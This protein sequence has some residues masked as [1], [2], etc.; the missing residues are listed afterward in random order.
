[1]MHVQWRVKRGPASH[2]GSAVWRKSSPEK[3]I[4]IDLLSELLLRLNWRRVC[5]SRPRTRVPGTNGRP[6][7]WPTSPARAS[8]PKG[9]S[10]FLRRDPGYQTGSRRP[11]VQA[12]VLPNRHGA[13]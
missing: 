7:Y 5:G 2:A 3:L 8:P 6:A 10:R 4:E 1:M 12:D 9:L 13:G 11:A